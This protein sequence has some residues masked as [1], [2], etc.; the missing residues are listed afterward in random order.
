MRC[1]REKLYE[2]DVESFD[3]LI[4][5]RNPNGN[6]MPERQRQHTMLEEKEKAPDVPIHDAR[7]LKR[8]TE[9]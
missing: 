4:A 9:E 3:V 5:R 6:E 7:Q 1:A 2:E 8:V